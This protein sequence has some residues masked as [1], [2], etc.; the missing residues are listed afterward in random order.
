MANGDEFRF[1]QQR[2]EALKEE[3]GIK[4]KLTE[5]ERTSLDLVRKSSRQ[6]L[7]LI[8]KQASGLRSIK[9]IEGDISRAKALQ[10]QLATQVQNT[11]GETQ[12]ILADS[13]EIQKEIISKA[14]KE[15]EI[16]EGVENSL[17]LSGKALGF[18]NNLLGSNNSLTNEI[19]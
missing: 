8:G 19:L 10:E 2:V 6:A 14:E 18:I 7:D 12:R 4:T 17:G 1:Q 13:N 16:R 15:L 5:E 3:L 9:E 11:E